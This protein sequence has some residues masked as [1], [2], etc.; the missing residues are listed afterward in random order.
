MRIPTPLSALLFSCLAIAATPSYAANLVSL[1]LDSE[2]RSL[3]P[4]YAVDANSQY[5]MDLTHCSLISFNEDGQ[6]IPS[7]AESW[8]WSG[9]K[10]ITFKLKKGI[11]FSD[12][13]DV[14]VEDVKATYEFFK[15]S[16]L[17]NP[18]PLSGAFA[19][20]A[21]IATKDQEITFALASPDTSFLQ[22]F[23]IGVLPKALASGEMLTADKPQ[24]GCG[25]FNLSKADVSGMTLVKNNAYNLGTP[26]TIDQI[27]IKIVK[28]E[29]T[30]YAKLLKGEIDI[31]QNGISRDK[32]SDLAKTAPHLTILRR[33]GINST[34]LGFN[35]R[36]KTL[37]SVKVR[38]AI[39]H[40]INRKEIIDYIL[41]GM[42]VPAKTLLTPNDPFL[43]PKLPEINFDP[44]LANK[45][46][47]EA[48]FKDPDGKGKS[49]R[50]ELSYKTTTDT[51]RVSIAQAIASQ[52]AKVGIKVSV[53]SLE[54]G[55]FKQDI[56]KGQV[57][58]WSL[59]WIGFKDPDIYRHA[60]G[61][62]SFPPNGG[63]RGWYS[64]K[65]LDALLTKARAATDKEQRKQLYFD[66]Q[67]KVSEDMPYAFLWHEETTAVVN[68][69]IKGFKL[70][71]DGR[72][73]AL[74]KVTTK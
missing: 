54:W 66:V 2:P 37:A 45:L 39:A 35:M 12:G 57:Q 18:S 33:A 36:D 23:M 70:Y 13:K 8:A 32:I 68:K 74:S 24:V 65:E 56:E 63:N 16:G 43:N 49:P 51:T 3:D 10:A 34:Y 52:L 73:S 17:K 44:A 26:S 60:F 21:S 59:S 5:L 69:R 50:F 47:D 20:I 55:K 38:Q 71:A 72:L 1:A 40:A 28:D 42:A 48:G 14:T 61:T 31:V 64:N 4:R 62:E 58:M 9:D 11:K 15:Q 19:L 25:A 6:T 30:R 7:L 46:L 29:Q 22:N 27:D 53:Q 67:T 41:K